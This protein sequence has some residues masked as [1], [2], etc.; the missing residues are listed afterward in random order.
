VCPDRPVT[1]LAGHPNTD[2]TPPG[3]L[4]RIFDIPGEDEPVAPFMVSHWSLERGADSGVDQ[5]SVREFWLIAAGRGVM[6]C[7]GVS[8]DVSTG[9]VISL[10]PNEPHTLVNN[11]D[12][13]CEVF[14]VWWS[15]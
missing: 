8:L 6:T 10:E 13:P 11:G 3:M 15:D 2:S 7:G 14:S 9:D 5:H 4:L 1:K 12:G